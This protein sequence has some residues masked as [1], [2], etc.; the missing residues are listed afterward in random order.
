MVDESADMDKIDR[1]LITELLANGRATYQEL[2]RKVTLSAN[3]VADRVKRLQ[4][5]GVLAGFHAKV[6]LGALG[7][8]L[9]LLVDVQLREDVRREDFERGLSDLPQVIAAVHL[10]GDYDYELRVICT[11]TDEFETVMDQFKRNHGVRRLRSRLI[12][13]EVSLGP[14]RLVQ[15]SQ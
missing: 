8:S 14:A 4:Q 11:N 12:L 6:D 5:S 9:R 1:A 10:T 15:R 13:R 2:G 7:R 3:T